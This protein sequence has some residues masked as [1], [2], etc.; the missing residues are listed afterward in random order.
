MF[1]H[2]VFH[3]I[4]IIFKLY[5]V[6]SC[7]AQVLVLKRGGL[8]VGKRL[9]FFSVVLPEIKKMQQCYLI[10][11]Q[12]DRCFV[13]ASCSRIQCQN[14]LT[15]G[16]FR[17]MLGLVTIGYRYYISRRYEIS[18]KDDHVR[19]TKNTGI[20]V[21]NLLFLSVFVLI[22]IFYLIPAWRVRRIL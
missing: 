12:N 11:R 20:Y 7:G 4:V 5:L 10:W 8:G 18:S 2:H 15:G 13:K 17:Q 21:V 6:A 14:I 1:R 16:Y 19:R 9:E 3:F 22:H